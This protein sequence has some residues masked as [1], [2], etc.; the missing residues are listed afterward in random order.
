MRRMID[1]FAEYEKLIIGARTKG[2]LQAKRRRGEKTG[3]PVPFGFQAGPDK[4]AADGSITRTLLTCA[5]EQEIIRLVCE[6]RDAGETMQAIADNLNARG[7]SRRQ[8]ASWDRA[9]VFKIL[10]RAS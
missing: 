4:I 10:K 9:F 7:I 5:T 6:L 8:G 2:A 1:A 3:G